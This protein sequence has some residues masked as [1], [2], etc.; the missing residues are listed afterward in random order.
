[1]IVG[2]V[3]KANSILGIAHDLSKVSDGSLEECRSA[4]SVRKDSQA[5]YNR[6]NVLNPARVLAL[7][8][9]MLDKV[10]TVR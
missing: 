7:F 9:R 8:K 5:N 10:H 3:K 6:V 2:T 1:M 4:V